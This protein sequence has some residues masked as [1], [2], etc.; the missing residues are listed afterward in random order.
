MRTKSISPTFLNVIEL[1]GNYSTVAELANGAYSSL[2]AIQLLQDDAN[3]TVGKIIYKNNSVIVM[4]SNSKFESNQKHVFKNADY[5]F[6]WIGPY[7]IFYN[8]QIIK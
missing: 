7:A 8:N 6:E 2:S 1:H 3:Y 4:Q 5:N